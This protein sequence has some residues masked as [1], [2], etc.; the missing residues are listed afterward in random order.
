MLSIS[1]LLLP[2]LPSQGLGTPCLKTQQSLTSQKTRFSC[3]LLDIISSTTGKK[4]GGKGQ[5][6]V[7]ERQHTSMTK[8]AKPRTTNSESN[9][10]PQG[11]A[12][13]IIGATSHIPYIK[14]SSHTEMA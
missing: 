6:S 7:V 14:R 1:L 8:H 5:G 11:L 10:P 4:G 9:Y 2:S 12:C 13:Y 3:Y